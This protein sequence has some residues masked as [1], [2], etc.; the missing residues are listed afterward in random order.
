MKRNASRDKR[1][2]NSHRAYADSYKSLQLII[3]KHDLNPDRLIDAFVDAWINTTSHFAEWTIRCRQQQDESANF[4]ITS[5][6]KVIAQFP[7]SRVIL[8]DADR[9]KRLFKDAPQHSPKSTSTQQRETIANLRPGMKHVTI[10]GT[11]Q[12][13]SSTTV[14][15]TRW[16]TE[17]VV[18]NATITDGSG[19]ILFSLWNA[20]IDRV[21]EGDSIEIRDGYIVAYHGALQIRLKRNGSYQILN[22][23]SAQ[24]IHE[25]AHDRSLSTR[26]SVELASS[27]S[28]AI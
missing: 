28:N 12:H 20:Q 15:T 23:S 26:E 6:D 27:S 13:I 17:A 19:T 10:A 14:V 8:K 21:Q 18:A 4:L 5:G 3:E 24:S 22:A 11:V 2:R 25:Q 1:R 9:L 16:G 7:M